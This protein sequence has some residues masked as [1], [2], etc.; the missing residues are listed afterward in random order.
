LISLSLSLSLSQIKLHNLDA[1]RIAHTPTIGS[2]KEQVTDFEGLLSE[3]QRQNLAVT[4]LNVDF[5][6]DRDFFVDNLLI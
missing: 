6:R 4:V 1:I 3:S 2:G 5:Q